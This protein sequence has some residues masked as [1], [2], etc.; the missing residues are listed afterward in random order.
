MS[1][2]TRQQVTEILADRWSLDEQDGWDDFGEETIDDIEKVYA[3][4]R[5]EAI[6]AAV[7]VVVGQRESGGAVGLYQQ[8]QSSV[9]YHVTPPDDE[10]GENT[11]GE[12]SLNRWDDQGT[13]VE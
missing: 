3:Q 10:Y 12:I 11:R 5:R 6:A 7:A 9:V 8:D 13:Y 4:E 1:N 2:K